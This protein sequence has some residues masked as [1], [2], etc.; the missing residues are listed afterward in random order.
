[1]RVHV[2]TLHYG[3]AINIVPVIETIEILWL[4]KWCKF[5]IRNEFVQITL[6]LRVYG[7]LKFSSV[8]MISRDNTFHP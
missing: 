1:M 8:T 5:G 4:D 3:S 6:A 2:H 7:Y